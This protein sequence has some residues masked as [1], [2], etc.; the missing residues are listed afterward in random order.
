MHDRQT[1]ATAQLVASLLMFGTLGLFVRLIPLAPTMLALTRGLMGAA[2]LMLVLHVRGKR[3]QLPEDERT[4]VILLASGVAVTLNWV[5]LFMAYERTTLA[6]AELAYEMAPVYVMLISPFVLGERFTR[7][8]TVCLVAA[9]LGMVLVSGVL[10]PGAATGINLEGVGLGLISAGFFATT[11]VLNQL[12][13]PIEPYTKTIVQLFV[14]GVVLI[15]YAAVSG[16]LN[17]DGV[18]LR[19]ALLVGIVGIVH[20]GVAFALW[21]DALLIAVS[22]H[23]QS[24]ISIP[25]NLTDCLKKLGLADQ[26][27]AQSNG[28]SAYFFPLREDADAGKAMAVLEEH[29][30]EFGI[31]RLYSREDLDSMH[32]VSGV[33]FACE[34]ADQVVFSDGLDENKREKATHGFGPGHRAENCL[35]AV[36]GKGIRPGVELPSMPMRDVAPTIAGLMGISLPSARGRD[37]SREILEG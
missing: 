7:T 25:V 35:F 1:R 27:G 15:P 31:L 13:G 37:H 23:G 32:A 30:P 19:E 26:F 22:D 6:S 29:L 10:E 18:G 34:A 8:K 20:T 11:I 9:V 5:F 24:D 36:V 16:V 28:E 2:F 12:M 33:A 21:F 3:L 17:F 14:A 4:R